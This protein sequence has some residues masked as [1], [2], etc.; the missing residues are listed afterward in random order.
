MAW[1]RTRNSPISQ[2]SWGTA[3]V[4][5]LASVAFGSLKEMRPSRLG[6]KFV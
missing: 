2:R 6:A 4:T 1:A 5:W 3:F